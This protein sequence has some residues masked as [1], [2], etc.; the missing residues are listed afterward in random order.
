MQPGTPKQPQGNELIPPPSPPPAVQS[1]TLPL[2]N[3]QVDEEKVSEPSWKRPWVWIRGKYNS[4]RS[5]K[6]DKDASFKRSEEGFDASFRESTSRSSVSLVAPLSKG[7]W[8]VSKIKRS[9]LAGRSTCGLWS[10]KEI[11]VFARTKFK[12]LKS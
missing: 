3:V 7:G 9:L 10:R 6:Q 2:P 1:S 11:L 4:K 12:S 8:R 5:D